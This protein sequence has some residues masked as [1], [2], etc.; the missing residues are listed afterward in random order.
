MMFFPMRRNVNNMTSLVPM[1]LMSKDGVDQGETG[2]RLEANLPLASTTP[3]SVKM[4]EVLILTKT[5]ISISILMIFLKTAILSEILLEMVSSRTIVIMY[6]KCST[7][8]N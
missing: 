8:I 3:F 5:S 4:V 2:A 7:N 1:D 6:C